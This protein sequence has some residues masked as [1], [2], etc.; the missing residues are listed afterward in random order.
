VQ[1]DTL[2]QQFGYDSQ[3]GNPLEKE[4]AVTYQDIPD[5]FFTLE[6]Q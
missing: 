6:K 2:R 5:Y 3:T 1:K 4:P